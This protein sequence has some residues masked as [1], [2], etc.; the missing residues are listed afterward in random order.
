VGLR[1]RTSETCEKNLLEKIQ[2]LEEQVQLA[3][4]K[5]MEVATQRETKVKE[6]IKRTKWKALALE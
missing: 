4:A 3:N 1:Q 5:A 2:G 6:D